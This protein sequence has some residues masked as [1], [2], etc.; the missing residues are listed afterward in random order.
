MICT[1]INASAQVHA[2]LYGHIHTDIP[3]IYIIYLSR[4]MLKLKRVTMR[5]RRGDAEDGT[6]E[7]E[8]GVEQT[9]SAGVFRPT[10][11]SGPLVRL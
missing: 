10:N 3:S 8:G 9:S 11:S 2:S 6:E 5:T 4:D 1:Y 7:D